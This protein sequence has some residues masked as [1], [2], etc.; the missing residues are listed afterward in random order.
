MFPSV[1]SWAGADPRA[2]PE[3]TARAVAVRV[4]GAAS[5]ITARIGEALRPPVASE[6]GTETASSDRGRIERAEQA[7]PGGRT[8]PGQASLLVAEPV[9]RDDLV[10]IHRDAAEFFRYH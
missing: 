8:V 5:R 6:G 2:R 7:K 1:S 10:R 9:A 4:T 3:V